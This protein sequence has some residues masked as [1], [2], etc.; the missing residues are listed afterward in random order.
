MQF[1][2]VQTDKQPTYQPINRGDSIL[3]AFAVN[4]VR[5]WLII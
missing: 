4:D 5:K 2:V 3:D 1:W